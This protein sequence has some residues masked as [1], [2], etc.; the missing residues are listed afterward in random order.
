MKRLLICFACFTGVLAVPLAF[1]QPMNPAT[2]RGQ[3]QKLKTD[4]NFN[5]SYK[6]FRR[7]CLDPNAGANLVGQDLTSAVECLQRLGRIQEF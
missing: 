5:D 7:L 3:A 1:S 6:A 2:L 4:G